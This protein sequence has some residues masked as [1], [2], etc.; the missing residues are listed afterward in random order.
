[1]LHV[2]A[3]VVHALLMEVHRGMAILASIV[4]GLVGMALLVIRCG[5]HSQR[6]MH[7]HRKVIVVMRAHWM[8]VMNQRGM[9]GKVSTVASIIGDKAL[10]LYLR[11]VVAKC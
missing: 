3:K 1:M 2:R 5:T 11:Y 4:V 8:V 6:P 9:A 7:P 10:S